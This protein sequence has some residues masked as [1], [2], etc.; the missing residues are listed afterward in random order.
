MWVKS[1]DV[2]NGVPGKAAHPDEVASQGLSTLRAARLDP[3]PGA[4]SAAPK[5]DGGS[6]KAGSAR[7][8]SPTSTHPGPAGVKL[9]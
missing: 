7:A 9:C 2:T 5:G 3:W 6:P 8:P 4:R 1:R